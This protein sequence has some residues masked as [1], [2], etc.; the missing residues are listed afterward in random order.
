[1]SECP[2]DVRLA[3]TPYLVI[4]KMALQAMPLDWRNRLEALLAEADA[5][6]IECPA[7][8]VLRDATS[9]D[10]DGAAVV[11]ERTGF[12]RIVRAPRDPWADYRHASHET[13][14]G[15]SPRFVPPEAAS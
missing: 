1:M 2:F 11:D 10:P 12:I 4:P 15:L 8:V 13:V 14:R 7:Y 6:G 5:T 3:R 9:G